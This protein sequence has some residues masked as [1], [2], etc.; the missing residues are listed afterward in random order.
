M[1]E[2]SRWTYGELA[3][4]IDACAKALLAHGIGPGDR[5]YHEELAALTAR[6]PSIERAVLL[7]AGDSY[8]EF[9][10]GGRRI[11]DPELAAARAAVDP[12]ATCVIVYTSGTTGEPK[13]A[14]IHQAG[15]IKVARVQYAIWPID[16]ARALN[17]LP[18]NHIGCIGDVTGDTLVPGGTL[19]F[20][21]QF[22][23]G[24]ML[25]A[26]AGERLT[27]FGHVPTAL[28]LIVSHP[29]FDTTDFSSVQLNIWEGAA[30]P[31]K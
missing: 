8:A 17:N 13:G 16:P 3:D 29:A 27:L 25:E 21:E 20:Q 23:P 31:A 26:V 2:S 5:S 28:Q 24:A 22:D 15:L 11:T 12:R 4:R 14:M 10:A 18:I 30:A 7:D 19:V 6:G 1:F 9:I